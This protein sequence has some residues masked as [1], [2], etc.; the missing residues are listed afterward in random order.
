MKFVI[1]HSSTATEPRNTSNQKLVSFRKGIKRGETA[2]PTLKDERYFDSFS[3]SLY[4]TAKSHECEDVLDPEYTLSN[5]EKELLVAKQAFMFSVFDKHLLTDMGKTIVRKYVH[6][7]DAQSVW[8]DFQEH[9]KSSS[10][11]SS[12]KRR[13]T[14]YVTNTVL[15]DNY[16]VTKEQFVLH[17]SEQFRQLEEI[18]EESEH[19]PPQIKLQL[20]QN[21]VRPIND[22]RIVETLDEFQ[23]ITTGCGRSTSLKYQTY[24]DLLINACIR[25]DRT[26]KAN[27]AK[28]GHIYQTTF[29]QSNDNFIDQIPSETPIGD[30]YMG[31]D[32]P[33]DEFYYINTNQSGPPMSAR[34][35]LQPRLLRSNPNTK[36]NTFPKKSARQKWTGPI[37]LPAHIYKLLSQEAKDALQKYNVEAIQKF[38]ASRNLNETDLMHNVYEHT[39]EE[40]PPS[41]DEEEFQECEQFNTDQDLDPPTDDILEFITSQEHS[42]DQLDQV[43]QT[44]QAYQQSQS[45]TEPPPRQMNAHITYHV[46]QAKQAKH[47]SLV[48]RGANGGLA[49][50]DVR[51]LSTSP[52]TCTVTGIDN[53]DIPGLDLVQCEALVQTNHGI[54]NLIMNEYAYY[55]IGHCILSSCQIEWYTNTEDDKSIQVGGQQRI[56][57]IDGY[58]MPLVCKDGLMYL[59]LQGIPT[60]QDLQNYPSDHLT[61]LHEWDPSVLDYEH[62][63]NNGEPDWAIDPNEKFQ[64]D[65]NF[66]EFGDYVNR[67]LSILDILD[68]TPKTSPIH[69]LLANKHVFQ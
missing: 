3:R 17:F 56:V 51:I 68:E 54:I 40:L 45:E 34:H 38:K 64:F 53:H 69:N 48:D 59:Q 15:D 30:P 19:F 32:T 26:K 24:Y 10:K 50:S 5:S 46:A 27:V 16:K 29:S 14:Q 60:D 42:D 67:S 36:P 63:E 13:Y 61:S 18:S 47:G 25:Y 39:Q 49:G 41:T 57:T 9:M 6:T 21:A 52:R 55:G 44:Y 28:R 66:D 7:T 65:P 22:L 2:Y 23:S 20:L 37:F 12:E 43:L 31:I 11:G 58:S 4:I 33:S 8:K 62:P 35:K 1:Y